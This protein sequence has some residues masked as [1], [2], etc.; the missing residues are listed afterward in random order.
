MGLLGPF[1]LRVDRRAVSV[2]AGQ[3]VVLA[4]LALAA[5]RV[6]G[7]DVLAEALWA[8]DLPRDPRNAVQ[9]A[10]FRVR[11]LLGADR[12]TTVPG[13]YRLELPRRSVDALRFAELAGS[14]PDAALAL[15]RGAPLTGVP[16]DAL[17]RDHVPQLTEAYLAAV[18]RRADRDPAAALGELRELTGRYPLRESLWLRLLTGLARAGRQAEALAGYERLRRLLAES[19]GTDPSPELRRVHGELLLAGVP[20]E[21]PAAVPRQ[22]PPDPPGFTGRAADLAALD[23]ADAGVLAVHGAGGVGK[24]ALAVRWAHRA[25]DRYPDG[26]LYLDLR[27]YGPDDPMPP[28]VALDVLLRALGCP[29]D[30]VPAGVAERSALLRTRLAD[31]RMLVLLDNA[32]DADQVRPLLPGGAN[33]ALVTSRNELRGLAVRDGALRH[34]LRELPRAESVALVRTALGAE[35]TDAEPAAVAELIA[36]CGDLPLA[37]VIAAEQA[38]RYPDWSVAESVADLRAARDRLDALGDGTDPATDPRTVIS[39]SYAAL[40]DEAAAAFRCLGSHPVPEIELGAAAALIGV[41]DGAARRVLDRLVAVHL[42]ARSAPRRY[43]LH[44]LVYLFAAERAA[45]DPPDPAAVSRMLGWYRGTL[46]AAR[47]AAFG[48]VPTEPPAGCTF[49]DGAAAVRWYEESRPRLLA[50]FRHAAAAGYDADVCRLAWLLQDHQSAGHHATDKL[51]C[52]EAAARAADRSGGP[53]DRARARYL[54]G[55]ALHTLGDNARAV[56]W[57]RRALAEQPDDPDLTSTILSAL[58]LVHVDAGAV[59]EAADVLDRSVRLARDSDRPLRLAHSLL[60][61]AVAED[62]AGRHARAAGHNREALA[63]YRAESATYHQ[64]LVL[65]NLSENLLAMGHPDEALAHATE[66]VTVLDGVDDTFAVPNALIAQ[67][68]ALAAT[69]DTAAARAVLVRVHGVLADAGQ[70]RAAE[71]AELLAGLDGDR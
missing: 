14:D 46:D 61:L 39:W 43:R 45:A 3:R 49:D 2:P 53:V 10:V 50:V 5:G 4:A 21:R 7:V 32:R 44:D 63:L 8:S 70:P 64:G 71:A 62:A 26:Q 28:A 38:A 68:R 55:C 51:E 59:D 33:L 34:H 15:W 41:P 36:L 12:V 54:V 47:V 18:E 52:A 13:G 57:H 29:P 65:A 60:N 66:A 48:S 6:V 23:A 22:L 17:H 40:D 27:G 42:L 1:E 35:R 19:L 30:Q 37:I 31:R 16:S 11:R 25:A 58:G 56:E 20:E 69:G 9:I 67:A 24:T